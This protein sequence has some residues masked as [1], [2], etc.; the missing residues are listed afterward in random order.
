MPVNGF[1]VFW[2][3]YPRRV[4]KQAAFR[5]YAKLKVTAELQAKILGALAAQRT[6]RR[7][8]EDG[9]RYIPN[10]ATWLH[11]GRWDDEPVQLPT[12]SETTMATVEAGQRWL[13]RHKR[14]FHNQD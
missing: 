1:E 11:Q 9:G 2:Q 12:V 13:A 7:W 5:E 8:L 3:A 10:P 14:K 6:N 4:G